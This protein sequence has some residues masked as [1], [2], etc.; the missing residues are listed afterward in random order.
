MCVPTVWSEGQEEEDEVCHH[1]YQRK[2][3]EQLLGV[4]VELVDLEGAPLHQQLIPACM[5]APQ[6]EQQLNRR[7]HELAVQAVQQWPTA[8]QPAAVRCGGVAT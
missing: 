3:V 2:L 4:G 5:H 8:H 7:A 1:V 6:I